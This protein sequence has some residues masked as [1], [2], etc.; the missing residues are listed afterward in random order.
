[1]TAYEACTSYIAYSSSEG[2]TVNTVV[3]FGATQGIPPERSRHR[4]QSWLFAVFWI[5]LLFARGRFQ[6][7]IEGVRWVL[8][9][10]AVR[11]T[12]FVLRSVRFRLFVPPASLCCRASLTCLY[13]AN[14]LRSTFV[15]GSFFG[16]IALLLTEM[17]QF[18]LRIFLGQHEL[19]SEA[20]SVV[21]H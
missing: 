19:F 16:S 11:L 8:F 7:I 9:S 17:R 6:R 1:M 5:G 4:Q 12:G 3:T 20:M 15:L 13:L 18:G 2:N 10:G 14:A 21:H